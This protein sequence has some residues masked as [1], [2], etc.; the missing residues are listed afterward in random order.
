MQ[1]GKFRAK[2]VNMIDHKLRVPSG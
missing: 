1:L 2:S